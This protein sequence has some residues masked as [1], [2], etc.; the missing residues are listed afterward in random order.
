MSVAAIYTTTVEWTGEH[1][2]NVIMGNG[3]EM[4]FSA[5]PE[6][7]GHEGVL[8]PE[9][10]FVAAINSCIMLMFLWAA[11]RF[12]LELRGY[13]CRA[14]GAK[15]IALD[16]TERFTS[17]RLTPA[18]RVAAGD[19]DPELIRSRVERA[20]AAARKYS[21]VASSINSELIIEPS[22][23]IITCTNHQLPGGKSMNRAG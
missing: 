14:E 19:T 3:P 4:P 17:V 10:A 16:R 21:L 12:K 18:I 11:K 20:M 2:G 5:P 23:E 8:T 15:E 9:D 13:R 7:H 22:L 1:W 6:A